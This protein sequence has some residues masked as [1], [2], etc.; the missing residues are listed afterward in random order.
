[1]SSVQ[2]VRVDHTVCLHYV[3]DPRAGGPIGVEVVDS[4]QGTFP[5]RLILRG[6]HVRLEPLESDVHAKSIY[7]VPK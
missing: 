1:M 6:Q 7:E 4:T 5:E 2:N 3:E